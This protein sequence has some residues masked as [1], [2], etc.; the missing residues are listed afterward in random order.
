[1]Q[2]ALSQNA[3]RTNLIRWWQLRPTRHVHEKLS[4]VSQAVLPFNEWANVIVID[5]LRTQKWREIFF[6]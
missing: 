4:K 6:F 5:T 3:K 1:M 2:S